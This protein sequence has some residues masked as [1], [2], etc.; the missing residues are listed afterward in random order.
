MLKTFEIR[1]FPTNLKTVER[2][3]HTLYHIH[4]LTFLLVR[5]NE[6]GIFLPKIISR[7]SLP[8]AVP[9]PPPPPTYSNSK[10]LFL[11]L[12][13]S[14]LG[15]KHLWSPKSLAQVHMIKLTPSLLQH[16][17]TQHICSIVDT[18]KMQQIMSYYSPL[19]VSKRLEH[20]SQRPPVFPRIHW[21]SR[22]GDIVAPINVS[23]TLR[24]LFTVGLLTLG[25]ADD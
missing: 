21:F 23:V 13:I 10:L 7:R 19:C 4:Q 20:Q 15:F 12:K 3:R 24:H 11:D 2:F 1:N 16:Q 17:K 8:I 6:A 18:F 25:P 22:Q 5:I 9:Y 14:S